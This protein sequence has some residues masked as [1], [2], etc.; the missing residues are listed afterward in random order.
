LDATLLARIQFAFTVAFHIVFPAFTIGLS[1]YIAVLEGVWFF[2]GDERFHRLARYWT[3]LF[4]VSFGMGVVSGVVMSYQFGTNWS[5]FSVVTGN[6]IGPLLGYEVLMAFFLEASF[7]GVMLFGWNRVPKWLHFFS[8]LMVAGGTL[9]SAFWILS[10]NSWMQYPTGHEV[11][12]GVAYPVDWIQV[13]FNPTF[14]LRFAHMAIAAYLTTSIV[15][16]AVGARYWLARQYPAEARI[17]I[18]MGLGLALVLAPLQLFIGDLH[19]LTTAEY[20]PAKLA[21]IEAHWDGTK[22]GE[23]VL[24]AIPNEAKGRNDF[25][26]GIPK[27]SSFIIT[28][29]WNGLYKGLADFPPADRPPVAVPFYAFRIM[30]GIGLFLILLALYGGV[31]WL[32][33]RLLDDRLFLQAAALSWP[34]GFI[35]LISGWIVTEVGR[36]PWAATGLI[37]TADA[38][39]PLAA[40]AVG[41]SLIL[42]V[43]VYFAVYS[44]GIYYMNLLIRRGP[45]LQAPS[46]QDWTHV[47]H[48]PI[49][50]AEPEAGGP[51]A[52]KRS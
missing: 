26:I 8:C 29:D 32:R 52:A 40:G 17:M 11:R 47:P 27:A 5:R 46:G 18:R 28:H 10:A 24:F 34:L 21:A 39:S 7:L 22:P 37:R 30:V 45:E 36:Q 16:L 3:K 48:R 25:D 15:V 23:L 12:D 41:A 6:V 44:A 42:F 19:G 14:P 38:G 33:G 2:D 9:L 31:Q 4:A 35:A 1:S 20:Q 49:S 43:L 13:I 51:L 50:A